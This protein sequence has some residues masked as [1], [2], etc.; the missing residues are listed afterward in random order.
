MQLNVFTNAQSS[1]SFKLIKALGSLTFAYEVS[2][3]IGDFIKAILVPHMGEKVAL[4]HASDAMELG[5][6]FRYK[7]ALRYHKLLLVLPDNHLET[8]RKGHTLL[9]RFITSQDI[10][11]EEILGVINKIYANSLSQNALKRPPPK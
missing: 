7:D 1:A 8:M 5:I 3:D 10:N 2:N 4:F 11:F 6:L 9:P